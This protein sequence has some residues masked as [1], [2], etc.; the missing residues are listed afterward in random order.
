MPEFA[1]PVLGDYL[2]SGFHLESLQE[3]QN[4]GSKLRA[5]WHPKICRAEVSGR[6]ALQ[7]GA[8]PG[9]GGLHA[10]GGLADVR[11][12]TFRWLAKRAPGES[13][14]AGQMG[15]RVRCGQR[16][17]LN[18]GLF[19]NKQSQAQARNAK[20]SWALEDRQ[21]SSFALFARP[22]LQQVGQR[23]LDLEGT[24][25]IQELLLGMLGVF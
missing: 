9:F 21:E 18:F 12:P 6:W 17:K 23:L 5:A 14:L 13:P 3:M 11:I 16:E 10:G 20:V 2:Y 25:Q 8:S 22:V 1:W 7:I 4:L 19:G 15:R 24:C